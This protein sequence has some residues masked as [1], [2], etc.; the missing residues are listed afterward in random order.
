MSRLSGI[1]GRITGGGLRI[2]SGL[3][4][5]LIAAAGFMLLILVILAGGVYYALKTSSPPSAVT[6]EP[7]TTTVPPT[8]TTL[9][10]ATTSSTSSTTTTSSTTST[11]QETTSTT[12]TLSKTAIA[13]CMQA[14]ITDIYIG[15]N[16]QSKNLVTYLSGYPEAF[17][18]TDCTNDDYKDECASDL[19]SRIENEDLIYDAKPSKSIGYP[20]VILSR[21]NKAY[22]IRSTSEFESLLDCG[23]LK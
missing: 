14:K 18:L 2:P 7:S 10:Q 8:T 17:L 15:A 22:I 11:T 13:F 23:S 21:D 12:T 16:P 5:T 6:A 9:A 19:K 3:S 20:A 4:I 1:G